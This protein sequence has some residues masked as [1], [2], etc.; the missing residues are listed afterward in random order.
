MHVQ[1]KKSLNF[2]NIFR[3]VLDIQNFFE[4]LSKSSAWKYRNV[5]TILEFH[6]DR[7]KFCYFIENLQ[8][9]VKSFLHIF[10]RYLNLINIIII[11]LCQ[12]FYHQCFHQYLKYI[13]NT[14][15]ID[16]N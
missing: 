14:I 4:F 1:T 13:K 10:L 9:Y 5:Y 15:E 16:E 2:R 6:F 11:L 3:I 7:A 8:N 12:I